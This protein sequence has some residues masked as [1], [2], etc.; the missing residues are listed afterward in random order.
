MA[1]NYWAPYHP[2]TSA[3]YP[4]PIR[5][6]PRRPSV[7]LSACPSVWKGR[8]ALIDIHSH[9]LPNIDDGSR[10]IEQSVEVLARFAVDGVRE[11]ILTPHL[12]ASDIERHGED[13][14]EERG[15]VFQTL[16][17]AMPS[18]PALHLG[19]EI[20][21]DEP[22]PVLATG[23]RRY[24]LAGSR[25][26][27]VEFPFAVVPRFAAKALKQ[28]V[29]A[30]VVPLIAHPERYH[31]CDVEAIS[32]WRQVGA[33][34]QVDATELVRRGTRGRQAREL[35]EAGVVDLVAGDNHG[36]SQTIATAAN[37][38]CDRGFEQAA[39]TLTIGNPKAVIDDAEM[40]DVPLVRFRE[41]WAHRIRTV[42]GG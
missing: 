11:L 30:G 28:M 10:S 42:L 17:A 21:L 27:L 18:G 29:R 6:H 34:V 25:C 1:E 33:M 38:L 15:E 31:Q 12:R 13:A 26:V 35:L 20:M 32:D 5:F 14:I 36:G 37:F 7:R 24:A 41:G 3:A 39:E 2:F 8:V 9:L 22:L 40:A 16:Q 4:P 19:F 23:D